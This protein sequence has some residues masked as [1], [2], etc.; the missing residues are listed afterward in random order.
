MFP[1]QG[2]QFEQFVGVFLLR[3]I[4][5]HLFTVFPPSLPFIPET[6]QIMQKFLIFN[7]EN[8]PYAKEV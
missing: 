2:K 5:E 7:F 3:K 8:C 4:S 1:S 6:I